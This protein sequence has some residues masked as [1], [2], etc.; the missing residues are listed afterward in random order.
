MRSRTAGNASGGAPFH[1]TGRPRGRRAAVRLGKLCSG[2]GLTAEPW[3]TERSR[4][5]GRE[6]LKR[7]EV[8]EGGRK[9]GREG[10]DCVSAAIWPIHRSRTSAL[11]AEEEGEEGEQRSPPLLCFPREEKSLCVGSIAFIVVHTTTVS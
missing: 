10:G 11:A 6:G 9:E 5:G 4:Q 8:R 1:F 7:K 2:K 3:A